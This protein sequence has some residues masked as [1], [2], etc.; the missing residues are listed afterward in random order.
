[1][2]KSLFQMNIKDSQV[3]L[4]LFERRVLEKVFPKVLI[5]NYAFDIE[6]LV[7]AHHYGYETMEIPV[8]LKMDFKHSSVKL[9]AINKSFWDTLAV[10]YR[11]RILKYY[12]QPKKIREAMLKKYKK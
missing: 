10:F 1:M 8:N 12:D 7:L 11:L 9:S 4:K 3:G 6:L 5:K 2:I